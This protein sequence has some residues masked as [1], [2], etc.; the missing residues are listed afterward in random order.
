MRQFRLGILNV[1]RLQ[2][3]VDF[4]GNREIVFSNRGAMS[5]PDMAFLSRI[6]GLYMQ[7]K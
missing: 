1:V 6:R 2:V 5:A 7:G 3:R 4:H